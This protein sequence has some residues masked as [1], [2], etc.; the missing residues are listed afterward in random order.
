VRARPI[1][2]QRLT[3]LNDRRDEDEIEEEFSQLT[4]FS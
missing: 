2:A 1:I 4:F 3:Q